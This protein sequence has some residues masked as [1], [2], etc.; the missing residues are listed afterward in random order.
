MSEGRSFDYIV[1]GAGSAGC[2][3]ANRLTEDPDTTV[4]LLEA[5]PPD[6]NPLIHIPLMLFKMVDHPKLNW[7]YWSTP[8]KHAHDRPVYVPRGKTLGGSSSI[9]GMVY[10]R[11]H[12]LDYDDWAKEGNKGW[13]Y[14][15]VLPYFR[16]SEN[17]ENKGD[18]IFHGAGGPQNVMYPEHPNPFCEVF[19]E[20]TDSLQLPR[21]DDFNGAKQEGFHYHQLTQKKGRRWSTSKGFL[22]PAKERKNLTVVTGCEVDRLAMDGRRASGVEFKQNGAKLTYSANREVVLAAGAFGSPSILMRSGIGDPAEISK[23]G[24]GVVQALPG[25]GKN[26]QDHWGVGIQSESMDTRLYGLSWRGLPRLIASGLEYALFRRG[27]LASNVIEAGGFVRSDP[28]RDRPDLQIGF[29]PVRIGMGAKLVGKGHG[30]LVNT[31][32]LRPKS[33]G[34]TTLKSANPS[35][36]PII[37]FNAFSDPDDMRVFVH[38]IKM[39]RRIAETPAFAP[40]R[41]REI[42]PG[43]RVNTDAEF[44]AWARERAATIYHA[45]GTCKMGTGKDAVVDAELK[46]HGIGGLRIVDASVMPTINAGNTNAPTIMIAEKGADMIRGRAPLAAAAV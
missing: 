2:V 33:R 20:A 18:S 26:L 35:D 12:R 3:L 37:D 14:S 23:H 8:Q 7:N 28:S 34:T 40:Y 27:M 36:A 45:V 9:N 16:R 10:I 46:V 29:M 21:T 17:N 22:R 32:L 38:G 44:D 24:I 19:F 25:V 4:C 13:S 42:F 5:G 1:V 43:P 31:V 15:E 30:Y 39:S 11:G 6:T 41:V